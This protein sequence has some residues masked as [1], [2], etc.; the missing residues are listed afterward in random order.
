VPSDTFRP[1]GQLTPDTARQ[2]AYQGPLGT[3]P[4]SP[5]FVPQGVPPVA[6]VTPVEPRPRRARRWLGVGIAVLAA[7]ILFTWW[8]ST[9]PDEEGGAAATGPSATVDPETSAPEVPATEPTTEPVEPTARAEASLV[10]QRGTPTIDG[11]GSEWPGTTFAYSDKV[12][13][14]DDTG[15]LGR[16]QLMCDDDEFY[17]FTEVADGD[18]RVPDPSRPTS[19]TPA[20]G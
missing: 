9:L 7:L 5:Y 4:A 11:H 1:A 3:P 10:A 14:G 20:T 18:L 6:P 19:C 13:F 2:Q 17:F 8:G 16:T 15:I 12:I